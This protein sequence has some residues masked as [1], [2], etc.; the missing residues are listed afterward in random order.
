[1]TEEDLVRELFG[2]D[3][4]LPA[5]MPRHLRTDFVLHATLAYGSRT[6]TPGA[7]TWRSWSRRV[8]EELADALP[9]GSAWVEGAPLIVMGS[10][11]SVEVQAGCSEDGELCLAGVSLSSWQAVVPPRVQDCPGDEADADIGDQ[12][13]ALA[14]RYADA[15]EVWAACVAAGSIGESSRVLGWASSRRCRFR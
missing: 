7:E 11:G 4:E 13:A 14:G 2:D 12:L 9:A 3:D 15:A 1:M 5:T 8:D 6:P 10:R